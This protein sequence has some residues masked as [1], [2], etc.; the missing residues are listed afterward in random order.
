MDPLQFSGHQ[1]S[2][3]SCF[4]DKK[5]GG[6]LIAKDFLYLKSPL[7]SLPSNQ[8]LGKTS[9]AQLCLPFGQVRWVLSANRRQ[10]KAP[11][12]LSDSSFLSS[13]PD[14]RQIK[15]RI[16]NK[17]I[18]RGTTPHTVPLPNPSPYHFHHFQWNSCV[19]WPMRF[20]LA[21]SLSVVASSTTPFLSHLCIYY[22]SFPTYYNKSRLN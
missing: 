2:P 3:Q 4:G 14:T 10:H 20:K 6:D 13:V 1:I 22:I 7:I 12:P 9:T 18:I 5:I 15:N 11:N 8:P 21:T 17:K 16:N 19:Q